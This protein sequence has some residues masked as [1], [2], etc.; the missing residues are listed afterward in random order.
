MFKN[1]GMK[2]S[3]D[4]ARYSIFAMVVGLSVSTALA[5]IALVGFIFFAI[6]SKKIKE[7]LGLVIGDPII[8]SSLMLFGALVVSVAWSV[9]DASIAWQWVSKYKKL[10]FIP[11]VALFFQERRH[12]VIFIKVVLASLVI[13]LFISY[14]NYFGITKV[15]NCPEKGCSTHSYIALSMLNCLLMIISLA[16]LLFSGGFKNKFSVFAISVLSLINVVWVLPS[17]TG[18]LMLICILV[19]VSVIFWASPE[20]HEKSKQKTFFVSMAVLIGCLVGLISTSQESRLIESVNKIVV[21]KEAALKSTDSDV[22]IDVRSEMYRKTIVLIAE[23]PL[24]GWGAGGQE[25]ILAR[26][27]EQGATANERYIFANPHNEY[28]LWAVQVGGLGL[29]LYLYW[30]ITIWWAAMKIEY[31]VD[32]VIVLC[33]LLIFTLGCFLNS[34]LLDFSEGYMTILLISVYIP[35][36]KKKDSS[37]GRC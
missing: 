4:F 5:N 32:R 30:L 15:G 28:L 1:N 20:N 3:E 31:L 9:A 19:M 12:K 7:E 35:L 21:H 16:W 18:Q 2:K 25:E 29:T 34:F 6:Q 22:A 10:L 11:L 36:S 17:R 33:W 27:S 23:K 26:M 14:L 13:G 37:S 24:L 8:C